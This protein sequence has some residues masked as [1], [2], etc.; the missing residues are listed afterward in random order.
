[1]I[2]HLVALSSSQL[3]R[4]KMLEEFPFPSQPSRLSS[5]WNLGGGGCCS[6]DI[7]HT[8][9]P[10]KQP[11][12]WG[13]SIPTSISTE[14]QQGECVAGCMLHSA[15]VACLGWGQ[16]F[17]GV[18]AQLLSAFPLCWTHSHCPVLSTAGGSGG[19]TGANTP[20]FYFSDKDI[21]LGAMLFLELDKY[22]ANG[23]RWLTPQSSDL[24]HRS[25]E[26]C[27]GSLYAEEI[28]CI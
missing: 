28:L 19:T 7:F 5:P 2:S 27:G 4:R 17:W 24:P 18:T 12:F 14:S 26:H 22:R 10:W 16:L 25:F 1:M 6:S 15:P 21:V 20:S 11:G 3:Q 9:F 13:T 8:S 23:R